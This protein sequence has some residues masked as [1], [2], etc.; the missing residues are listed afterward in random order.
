MPGYDEQLR[1]AVRAVQVHTATSY[2]W[3]GERS[4]RL[5]PGLKSALTPE[6]ASSLLRHTLQLRLYRDFY[7]LGWPQAGTRTAAAHRVRHAAD[8]VA[9]LSQANAGKGFWASGWTVRATEAGRLAVR[10]N[11]LELLAQA[12]DCAADGAAIAPGVPVGLRFPKE[13]LGASPGYYMALSDHELGTDRSDA[14]VR[15]YLNT[16]ASGAAPLMRSLTRALNDRSLPFQLKVASDPGG[17]ARCDSMVLYA[18][19]R[20][21]EAIVTVLAGALVDLQRY[22][23]ATTPAFT[24]VLAPGLGLAENP[25]Q[26][27]SFGLSRSRILAEARVRAH[28][29]GK[30]GEAD[31]LAA[32]EQGFADA[33]VSLATP[34]LNP[35]SADDYAFDAVV[36]PKRVAAGR[37]LDDRALDRRAEYLRTAREI[38]ARLVGQAIWHN[39]RCTWLGAQPRVLELDEGGAA[40]VYRTLG[41][42]LYCG[43]SGVA[44]F[45]AELSAA[46]GDAGLRRTARGAIDQALATVDAVPELVRLG[47]YTGWPG[48]AVAAAR[49]GSLLRDDCLHDQ[50][51]D[52]FRRAVHGL[53][54]TMRT[55]LLSGVA[56]GVVAAVVLHQILAQPWLLDAAAD[57]GDRLLGA[58]IASGSGDAW[59]LP[60]GHG[61]ALTGFSHGAA[62]I[63]HAL[64]ELAR[65]TG[66]AR[67]RQAAER[68]FAGERRWY[69]PSAGN[70]LDRRGPQRAS[71]FGSTWCHGAP[72]I[73]LSRLKAYGQ[74]G[75]DLYRDE[76]M[77]ALRTTDRIV[78][79]WLRAGG[80]SFCLC[81]G[82]A[83]N[84]EAMLHAEE[85]GERLLPDGLISASDVADA[86]IELHRAD[87]DRWPCGT[88]GGESPSLM[89]GLAGIGQ[90]YLRMSAPAARPLSCARPDTF[91]RLPQPSTAHQ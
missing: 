51:A 82:L 90:F 78:K 24:K 58:A 71:S 34:Y 46:T 63:G 2:S 50:A 13:M 21:Y 47:F 73:A 66:G 44:L 19:R 9:E 54:G 35:G 81:H 56:G 42:D 48:I 72:G 7:C 74:L 31:R 64:L 23:R 60:D 69:D 61:R 41:P 18:R 79:D 12:S 89:L 57:L 55:D 16:T 87:G 86:G 6:A 3:L 84:A 83:G 36:R 11:G 15:F 77:A 75:G 1:A 28:E 5:L 62:G 91:G 53:G 32:A 76:A 43:T 8:F 27:Q 14:L 52:L 25:V 4:P 40:P 26:D 80:A 33:G 30:T 17:F 37:R 20:D 67:Y 59:P 10:R 88:G 70:W 22:L 39:G 65:A 49:I 29:T 45:L 38:G 85:L 68:A